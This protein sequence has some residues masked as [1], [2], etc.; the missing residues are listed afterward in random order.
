MF[1]RKR[2]KF[3]KTSAA[4]AGQSR[5]SSLAHTKLVYADKQGHSLRIVPGDA[6]INGGLNS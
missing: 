4:A 1:H 2:H 3:L 5:I 6:L